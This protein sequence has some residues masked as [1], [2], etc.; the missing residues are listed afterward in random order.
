MI[1]TMRFAADRSRLE[2]MLMQPTGFK[3]TNYEA[4][5][6]IIHVGLEKDDLVGVSSVM[7]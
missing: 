2:W 4:I 5:D 7:D 3:V 6:K 1:N